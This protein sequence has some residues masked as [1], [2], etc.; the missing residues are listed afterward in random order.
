MAKKSSAHTFEYIL[1]GLIRNEPAH[2]YALF[3]KLQ[4]TPELSLIWQVKRSKLYYLLD[5]LEKDG[6]LSS[7]TSKEGP[8]PER[9]IYHIT[10]QGNDIFEDW[11]HAPVLSSRYVRLAFMSKLYFTLKES[12]E[13]S[14]NLIYAQ[15]EVCQTW[16]DNLEEGYKNQAQDG[17][18]TKQVYQFRIGQIKAMIL[19]LENCRNVLPEN[20][21]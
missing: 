3:E 18:I 4:I 7:T 19:W 12:L 2:G 15:L 16:L 14:Q 1:L 8:Y 9:Y 10:T 20:I 13:T 17:F 11:L 6:F 21:S 5:K